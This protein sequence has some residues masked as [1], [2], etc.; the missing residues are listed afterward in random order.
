MRRV[1]K[2]IAGAI[3]LVTVAFLIFP[4]GYLSVVASRSLSFGLDQYA[5]NLVDYYFDNEIR[6]D[7]SNT[8]YYGYMSSFDM[9]IPVYTPEPSNLL[10][11]GAEIEAVYLNGS[12]IASKANTDFIETLARHNTMLREKCRVE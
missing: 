9:I 10:R 2:L 8:S 7:C 1:Y 6:Y 11:M 4:A 12:D 5:V 3:S